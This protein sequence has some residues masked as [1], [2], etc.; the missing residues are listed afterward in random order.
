MKILKLNKA[1]APTN[2]ISSQEACTLL[3]KEMVLWQMGCV[4]NTL[5]GGTQRATGQRSFFDLPAIIAVEGAV[6]EKRVP[7]ISNRILFARDQYTCMYCGNTFQECD[8]TCDH[9]IPTSRGG[10]NGWTNCVTACRRCN[11]AKNDQTPEEWGHK[12]IAVPF[13]PVL[14]E[15]F[16]LSQ[17]KVLP[18]QFEYLKGGFK[19]LKRDAA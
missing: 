5:H 12:L 3:A 18:D 16:Y 10:E 6:H 4:A 1:G 19:N 13:A 14:F 11:H 7:Q 2:W 8:L 17:R 9:V 15:Y